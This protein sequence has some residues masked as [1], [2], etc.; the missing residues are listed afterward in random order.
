MLLG[1]FPNFQQICNYDPCAGSSYFLFY[2][3][4]LKK[5]S[6]YLLIQPQIILD[7]SY[8]KKLCLQ[9]F[10]RFSLKIILSSYLRLRKCWISKSQGPSGSRRFNTAPHPIGFGKERAARRTLRPGRSGTQGTVRRHPLPWRLWGIC[11]RSAFQE[12]SP[13]QFLRCW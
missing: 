11:A 3:V 4:F 10:S 2:T 12:G 1:L 9:N 5:V 13:G 7:F 6:N 8:S